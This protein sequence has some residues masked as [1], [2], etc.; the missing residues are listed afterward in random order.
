MPKTKIFS[1]DL[2]TKIVEAYKQGEKLIVIAKNFNMYR[3]TVSKIIKKFKERG[4]VQTAFKKGR[5]R[6][7]SVQTDRL[8]T[9]ISLADPKKTARQIYNELIQDNGL[10]CSIST[11]TV[12]RRLV[13]NG[14]F[15]RRPVKKP[16]ISKKNKQARIQFARDHI[17]WTNI[18]WNSVLFSDESKFMIFG[19]DGIKF[20]RR[21]VGKRFDPKYQLPTVKHGGGSIMVW[22]CFSKSGPGP[23]V[24]IDQIMDQYLY[25]D[26]LNR[27]MLPYAEENMPLQ[28]Q[29]Q[30]DND[31]KHTARSVKR[32]F[33]AKNVNVM[34]WPSQSPDLNPI[35]NLWDQIDRKIRKYNITNKDNLFEAIKLEWESLTE[36]TCSKLV[37][38]MQNRCQAVLLNKGFAT[39]Y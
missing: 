8:I 25:L 13:E 6:K 5:P 37:D 28:W 22:G 39:K 16:L 19:S 1:T 15:G 30:Q 31:P 7:T 26:I 27:H 21:P 32:W 23:I 20:V 14:L 12:R 4:T 33:E 3:G 9:R 34:Q 17:N 35:E 36:E 2:K 38:S 29:F 11:E 24:R 10:I 18:N